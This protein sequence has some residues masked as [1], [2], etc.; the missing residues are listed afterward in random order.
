ME[1]SIT[2]ITGTQIMHITNF[3]VEITRKC[4]LACAHCLRGPAQNLKIDINYLIPIFKKVES[5]SCL[6]LTGGEPSLAWK[7]I[8]EIIDLAKVHNVEIGNF[9][10]ATNGV[11]ISPE[12][13]IAVLKLYLYCSENE[14]TSMFISNNQ[15]YPKGRIRPEQIPFSFVHMGHEQIRPAFLLNEGNAK[16]NSIGA[17]RNIVIDEWIFEDGILDGYVYLNARGWVLDSCD[18][19]YESQ[20]EHKIVHVYDPHLWDKFAHHWKEACY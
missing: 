16:E 9:Y 15:Y 6:T 19:S 13:L 1:L 3:V 11:S 17:L 5:I 8:N 2:T 12:F 10:I 20:E 4:N 14:T 7:K 18:L